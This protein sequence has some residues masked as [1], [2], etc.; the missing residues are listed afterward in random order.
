ME[1]IEGV[2]TVPYHYEFGIFEPDIHEK[3]LL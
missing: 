1:D 3:P 2:R